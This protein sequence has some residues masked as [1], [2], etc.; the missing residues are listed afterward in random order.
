MNM[1]IALILSGGVGRRFD[2]TLP[3]QYHEINGKQVIAYVI[4]AVKEAKH[5]DKIIV[6]AHKEYRDLIET[7]YGCEWTEAG[8]ERNSSLKNGLEYVRRHYDCGKIVVF[9]AVRPLLPPGLTDKY[10]ELLDTY[11][12]VTTARKI[13]D[14]LGA[15]DTHQVDRERY[16]LMQSP[17]AFDFALLYR[18]FDENSRL[19]EVI[20]QLPEETK[21]F[22]CFDQFYNLKITYKEDLRVAA[23]FLGDARGGERRA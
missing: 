14:S 9:D 7:R 2:E 19:T 6:A 20:H 17:E 4:D 10:L 3:K 13:T 21:V 1:N 18:H 16:Y 5:I 11:Q 15:Y 12:A 22:L 8:N 23:L